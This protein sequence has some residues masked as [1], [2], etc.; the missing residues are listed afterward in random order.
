MANNYHGIPNVVG[1]LSDGQTGPQSTSTDCTAMVYIAGHA[2]DNLWINVYAQTTQ[3]VAT[4]KKFTIELQGYSADTASSAD[5]P[6]SVGNGGAIPQD[7]AGTHHNDG[8]YYIYYTTTADDATIF[9]AGDL[10]T[11][12][13]IPSDLFRQSSYDYVQLVYDADESWTGLI[14]AFVYVR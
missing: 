14:D 12:V 7:A 4:G 8:H 5:G 1:E 3:T 2:N 11:Q 9:A 6:F 10:I 13:A